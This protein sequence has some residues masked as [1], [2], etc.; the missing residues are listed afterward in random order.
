[1]SLA[2]AVYVAEVDGAHF[3]PVLVEHPPVQH[4]LSAAGAWV[5]WLPGC[6]E[7]VT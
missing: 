6:E 4:G 2:A 7:A 3:A 1:L 5:A